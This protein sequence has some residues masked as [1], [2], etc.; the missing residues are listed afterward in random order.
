MVAGG[1]GCRRDMFDQPR[2][3]PLR[4][5]EFFKDKTSARPLVPNTVPRGYLQEDEQFFT[6][7][8]GTNLV[9]TLP[10]ALNRQLLER[11]R[12]RFEIYCSVCH[13]RTGEGHGMIVQRGFPAPPA[14]D[15]ERLRQAPIGHFFDVIT[16]GYGVMYSY[17]N[18]V[19]PEDR[20][21][22]AAYIR[23]LQL[24][25]SAK[26]EDAPAAERAKLQGA[27]P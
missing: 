12:E 19:E 27:A 24:S 25:R 15:I 23:A 22:I 4:A 13:G 17:A 5:S 14:F 2:E 7:K 1:S 6:G 11:G 3:K 10:A 8:I 20:W 21:A 26:L 16:H 18:R 9:A